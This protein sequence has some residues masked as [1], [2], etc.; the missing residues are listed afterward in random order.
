MCI[1]HCSTLMYFAIRVHVVSI[2]AHH[3]SPSSG[4]GRRLVRHELTMSTVTGKYY[5][6]IDR[7]RIFRT[8]VCAVRWQGCQR[9]DHQWLFTGWS[10]S[11]IVSPCF[12]SATLTTRRGEY[13]AQRSWPPSLLCVQQ[14]GVSQKYLTCFLPPEAKG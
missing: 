7:C 10:C 3:P 8:V 11:W 9:V 1:L 14:G 4:C 6:D 12:C 5:M 2:E 13:G